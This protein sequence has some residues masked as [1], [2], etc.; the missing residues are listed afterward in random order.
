MRFGELR[1]ATTAVVVLGGPDLPSIGHTQG[2][3]RSICLPGFGER[4]VQQLSLA[5]LVPTW[6]VGCGSH[7]RGLSV[8]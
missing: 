5:L 2:F 3:R 8:A 4:N 6:L 7:V 1:F